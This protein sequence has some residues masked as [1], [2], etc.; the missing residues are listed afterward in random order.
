[1][2]NSVFSLRLKVS[3]LSAGRVCTESK[4][5]MS[6]AATVNERA[7]KEEKQPVLKI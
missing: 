4:F 5:Q 7:A 6:G 1:M 2:N 3:K